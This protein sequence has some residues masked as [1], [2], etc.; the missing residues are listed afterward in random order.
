M[1]QAKECVE[2]ESVDDERVTRVRLEKIVMIYADE[3]HLLGGLVVKNR[4]RK[5]LAVWT[6]REERQDVLVG[7]ETGLY[8]RAV[9]VV[10]PRRVREMGKLR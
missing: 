5:A 10:G 6:A 2:M 3:Y 1:M 8:A 9:A 7:F 4:W